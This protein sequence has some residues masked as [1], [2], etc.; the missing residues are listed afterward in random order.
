MRKKVTNCALR[1]A[2]ALTVLPTA[3]YLLLTF[4]LLN[5]KSHSQVTSIYW[6]QFNSK[7]ANLFLPSSA[8]LSQKSIERRTKQQI[9]VIENDYPVFQPYIQSVAGIADSVIHTLKWFNAITIKVADTNKLSSIRALA[10]V[11]TVQ[12]IDVPVSSAKQQEEKL[13]VDLQYTSAASNTDYGN[14][15]N[16]TSMLRLNKLHDAGYKGKGICIAVFDNGFTNVNQLPAYK[17]VFD[18]NRV[19]YTYDFANRNQNVYS[20]GMHG[21]YV[22][23]TIA[24]NEPGKFVGTAPD[25]DFLLFATE[26]DNSETIMEELHWAEAA[27]KADSIGADIFSTSLGYVTY[28]NNFPYR[29]YGD[30]AGNFTIITQ[31]ANIANSKG[32]LVINSAGN[33]GAKAWKY[34]SAPADGTDVFRVGSVDGNKVISNFSSRGPNASG[35]LKPEVCAQGGGV[36]VL[37]AGGFAAFS[38]GTSFSCPIIAGSAACLMQ[39][40]PSKSAN[41]IKNAIIKSAHLFSTPNNDYGYGIPNFLNEKLDSLVAGNTTLQ[42]FPNPLQASSQ[43]FMRNAKEGEVKIELAD[44]S[45]KV[46]HKLTVATLAN[47]LNLIP[48]PFTDLLSAGEYLLRIITPS[49]KKT[50]R[51]IKT[52]E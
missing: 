4:L 31:A 50:L 20:S 7:S 18:E 38:A 25:A 32:I 21:T 23:S 22:L 24:A 6:V 5:F 28:D 1:V 48:L 33:E 42:V 41:E 27:E 46:I 37:D 39:A 11:K 47:E 16:Q 3:C 29:S 52:D 13:K 2:S 30:M 9:P 14:A 51:V 12:R 43:L 35:Q 17:K 44:L 8:F 26:D 45:G 36:A 15:E 49:E 10:Y 40:A 34:I 19:L